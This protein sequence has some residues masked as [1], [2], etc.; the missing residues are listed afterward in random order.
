MIT[1]QGRARQGAGAAEVT[2]LHEEFSI[3][4]GEADRNAVGRMLSALG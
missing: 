3:R 2:K 4:V 1:D